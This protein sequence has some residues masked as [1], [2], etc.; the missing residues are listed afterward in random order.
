MY[1]L[2]DQFIDK[3]ITESTPE[4]PIWN[5]ESIKAGKKPHWNYIDGCMMTSL[6]ELYQETQEQKYLDFVINFVDYYVFD[7]GT[8]R[9]YNIESY[10]VDDICESRV[11]FDLFR[12]TKQEKY[13]K[14]IEFTYTHIKNQPRTKD[15]NFWHKKI[16]PNQ[17]WLDGLFMAQPFYARYETELN[18]KEN[19]I[20]I[21][22]QFKNVSQLMFNREK[23]LYYH[24]YDSTKKIFWANPETGLSKNFWLRAM[25]W[26][27]VAIVD[28][29]DYMDD[30]DS[31]TN[32]FSPLL[33]DSI[34]GILKYQDETSKM[35]Y[36]VVD[37]QDR[38]G[39]YLETSGSALMSYAI[40]KGVR[41]GLLENSYKQIGIDIFN[42]ICEKYLTEKDGDLNL[43]GIVLVSGLGPENNL[44]RDG[45]F[46][47]YISEPIVENDAKGVG[48]L[49][50]AYT[51]LKRITKKT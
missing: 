25:G 9:G 6:L 17:V 20:D 39:N 7:D 35:F 36:Q 8:I 31:K 4:R 27:F 50:M 38:K 22:N 10:N 21:I 29:V 12:Y 5:I 42:G 47:Y 19:Y 11:L 40:L 13:A 15:G 51:E 18:Q 16:Y 32:F 23:E 48:P 3:I 34:N 2:I 37:Q 26:F 46:E 33:R 49:I 30:E 45:S 28:V 1:Q 43:G 14:A 41:L 44:R 24:G